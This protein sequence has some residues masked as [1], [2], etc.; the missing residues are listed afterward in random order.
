MLD[1][2]PVDVR[3]LLKEPCFVYKTMRLPAVLAELRRSQM[4][5]AVVTDEYGGCL[6]VVSMEDVL[7]QIVGD[8]WDETDEVEPE[9]LERQDGAY[10]LDGNLTIGELAELMD[11][12]EDAID[13]DSAT[14]G[15]WTIENFGAFPS[16]GQSFAYGG[17]RF[18]VL[19]MDGLRVE[20]LLAEREAETE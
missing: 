13:T 16:A 7:E 11:L 17:W 15:G 1:G 12:D 18:T 4:H 3:A 14:V 19:G 5:L 6:G 20:K 9:I 2:V 8:I 10:E